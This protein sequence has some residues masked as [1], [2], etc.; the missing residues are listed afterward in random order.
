MSEIDE[1][2]AAGRNGAPLRT[3]TK[4]KTERVGLYGIT[5]EMRAF[6]ENEMSDK[7][8]AYIMRAVLTQLKKDGFNR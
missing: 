8:S 7:V 2:L 4:P 5:A 1:L 3:N 6:I